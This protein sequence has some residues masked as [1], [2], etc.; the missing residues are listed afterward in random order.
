MSDA[1]G[2]KAAVVNELRALVYSG[3]YPPG[4]KLPSESE[5]VAR[6]G[7][8]LY[9]MREALK[10]LN[11]QGLI[12]T[13]HGRG[14]T[15]VQVPGSY[16]Q[17]RTLADPGQILEPVGDPITVRSEA[18]TVLAET[19]NIRERAP[20]AVVEQKARHRVTKANVLTTRIVP[21]ESLFGFAPDPTPDPFGDRTA[22]LAA[23]TRHYGPMTATETV[24]F[25]LRPTAETAASLGMG[26]DERRPVVSIRRM[27][28]TEQG[29]LL[30]I[31]DETT[32][33]TT[34]ALQY[35]V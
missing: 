28:R 9:M 5:L 15:V 25:I 2:R 13:E 4:T 21:A 16:V 20:L 26:L 17:L 24:Q 7:G 8:S 34:A 18:T 6:F 10:E 3:E 29:R 11:R 23:L 12:E 30:L 35:Q 27:H 14:S 33:A 1:T 19:F 31:E 22:L 32:E